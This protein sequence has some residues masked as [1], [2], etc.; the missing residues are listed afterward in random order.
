MA[1]FVWIDKQ[2]GHI[3]YTEVEIPSPDDI[4][5]R[6]ESI[7]TAVCGNELEAE[8]AYTPEPYG[9]SGN[10]KLATACS[11][12]AFKQRCWRDANGGHG[13]RGY[14][15]SHGPVW[16]TDITRPPKASVPEIPNE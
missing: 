7:V 14:L 11:Y 12:C 6:A 5:K 15:Y 2:N 1:G 4:K 8:R 10:M 3:A 9:K 16:F 13:L